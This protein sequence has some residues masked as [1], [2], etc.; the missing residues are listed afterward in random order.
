MPTLQQTADLIVEA[1]GWKQAHPDTDGIFRFS[2]DGGLDFELLS[3]EAKTAV[4]RADLGDAPGFSAD[5]E[6]ALRRLASLAAGSLKARRS[7]LS[8]SEGRLELH[9]T[10][11]LADATPNSAVRDVRDFLND[12]A[13]W[14][15]QITGRNTDKT[16]SNTFSFSFGS[17]FSGN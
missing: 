13:W 11:A 10:F 7:T 9:R 3:P 12:L 14:K 1:A 4:L 5:D 15:K 17:W 8:I 2:L 16:S 6:E